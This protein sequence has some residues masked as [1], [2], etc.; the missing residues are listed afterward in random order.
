MSLCKAIHHAVGHDRGKIA[1]RSTGLPFS[2]DNVYSYPSI[3][4][5]NPPFMPGF[6]IIKIFFNET[7][8]MKVVSEL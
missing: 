5:D 8:P 3:Y 4:N 6:F 7:Y 2:K 1:V